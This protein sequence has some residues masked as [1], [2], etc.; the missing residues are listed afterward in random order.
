MVVGDLGRGGVAGLP[1]VEVGA[2]GAVG[3]ARRERDRLPSSEY[4]ASPTMITPDAI[5]IAPDGVLPGVALGTTIGLAGGWLPGASV[6]G[7]TVTGGSE[8]GWRSRRGWRSRA[9]RRR[10]CL[11]VWRRSCCWTGPRAGPAAATS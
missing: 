9:A 8:G 11:A 5:S 10:P 6:T 1:Q 3:R 4:A 2:G 7:G